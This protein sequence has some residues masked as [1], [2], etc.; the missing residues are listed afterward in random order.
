MLKGNVFSRIKNYEVELEKFAARWRSM[1][2]SEGV[3]EQDQEKVME[4]VRTIKD[5]KSEFEEL[6]KTREMLV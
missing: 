6:E 3:L 2:P 4:A 1:R 5:K